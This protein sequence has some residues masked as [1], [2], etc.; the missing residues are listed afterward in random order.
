MKPGEIILNG[1]SSETLGFRVQSRPTISSPR[2][3]LEFI[4]APGLSGSI[5]YNDNSFEDTPFE[6]TIIIK[7]TG[8]DDHYEIMDKIWDVY[9][10]FDTGQYV[11]MIPWF[12]DRKEYFVIPDEGKGPEFINNRYMDGHI[13]ATIPLKCRPYKYILGYVE[14][15]PTNF[16]NFTLVSPGRTHGGAPLII[17]DGNSV[18]SPNISVNGVKFNLISITDNLYI[19]SE[20]RMCYSIINGQY[21]NR[22]STVL[23]KEYPVLKK[24]SNNIIVTGSGITRVRVTPRW[25]SRI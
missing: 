17:L 16:N 3:R 13:V 19:D 5:V 25:R 24:G 9:N 1:L 23:T 4:D 22:N 10:Y 2:R 14:Q 18:D 21:I 15:T 12:D 20:S 7:G 11:S 6:L 8:R